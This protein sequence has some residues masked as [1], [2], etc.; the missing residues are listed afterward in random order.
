MRYYRVET[1]SSGSS[2]IEKASRFDKLERTPALCI[3][4]QRM[5]WVELPPLCAP[6]FNSHRKQ[7]K[8]EK[9]IKG[10][11]CADAA[12]RAGTGQRRLGFRLLVNSARTQRIC[13]LF[14]TRG[15][16]DPPPHQKCMCVC[17]YTEWLSYILRKGCVFRYRAPE[18][19]HWNWL[20]DLTK[21]SRPKRNFS[22]LCSALLLYNTSLTMCVCM[23]HRNKT[24]TT[25]IN[26]N[27][28]Y[29]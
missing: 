8:K 11:R 2:L 13:I 5:C 28:V 6:R 9:K 27:T 12:V 22:P 16:W 17:I 21:S 29:T 4:A 24:A 23:Y 15:D 26:N 1:G 7:K 20:A 14:F 10:G 3:V 19:S 25:A 18:T